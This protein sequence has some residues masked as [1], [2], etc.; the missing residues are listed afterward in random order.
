MIDL[1]KKPELCSLC[2]N[3]IKIEYYF[4][5][6]NG[7]FV[8]ESCSKNV[9]PIYSYSK[10]VTVSYLRELLEE[11]LR[12]FGKVDKINKD[13]SGIDRYYETI[14]FRAKELFE[15]LQVFLEEVFFGIQKDKDR[16]AISIDNKTKLYLSAIERWTKERQQEM[17]IEE[18][19]ELIQR[20]QHLKRG[21]CETQDLCE[22]IADVEITLEQLK[23]MYNIELICYNYKQS[24]L[25]R[26]EQRLNKK[27]QFYG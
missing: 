5:D 3:P 8:C 21:R 25:M 19:A 15:P 27:K 4:K 13:W 17:V 11:F 14:I 9:K 12:L 10:E 26:L 16:L 18:M 7:E 1:E 20:I 6:R 22:E 2:N 23:V 24:R